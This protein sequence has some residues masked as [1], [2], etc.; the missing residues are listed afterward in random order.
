MAGN[1]PGSQIIGVVLGAVLLFGTISLV[2]ILIM[3]HHRR[4]ATARRASEVHLLQVNGCMRQVTVERW[5]EEQT[6][7]SGN[8][9]QQQ[10]PPQYAQETCSICLSALFLAS[11]SSQDTLSL[12]PPPSPPPHPRSPPALHIR[13]TLTPDSDP[14][15]TLESS[16]IYHQYR[17]RDG[18]LILNQCNHAFH[19]ACLAS[20]FTY[21]QYKCPICQ[22]VYSPTTG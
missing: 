2:P 18:V 5:L 20:W 15:S 12:P 11:S 13:N 17:S 14:P 7:H 8:S 3:W 9:V 21:G 22:M 16:P 6:T 4:R 19:T 10:P 1:P